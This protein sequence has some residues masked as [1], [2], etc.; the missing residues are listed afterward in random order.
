MLSTRLWSTLGRPLARLSSSTIM[1]SLPESS[2]RVVV[3]DGGRTI[4]CWHPEEPFPYEFTQPLPVSAPAPEV[5]LL[6]D[7][8][9]SYRDMSP[10]ETRNKLAKLTY[11]TKHAWFPKSRLRKRKNIVPDREYL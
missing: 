1:P 9:F 5:T 2:E 6:K 7:L 11:T 10:E 3:A 4:V 8:K